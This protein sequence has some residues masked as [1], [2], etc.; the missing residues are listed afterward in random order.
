MDDDDNLDFFRGIAIA[1]GI[2]ALAACLFV[3][4]WRLS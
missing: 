1:I 2:E 3:V 4:I